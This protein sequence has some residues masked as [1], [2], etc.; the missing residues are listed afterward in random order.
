L[1][2]PTLER[3]LLENLESQGR[4][5]GQGYQAVVRRISSEFGEFVVKSPHPNNPL[6]ALFGRRAISREA[7]VY[8]R[9][10]GIQGIPR[11]FGLAASKHLVLEHVNGMTLRGAASALADRERFFDRLLAT[12]RAMHEAGIAHGDM[13]RK[14]N[15]LVSADET[16]CIIDFGVACLLKKKGGWLNRQRFE[17][18]RQMD[19][20]AWIKLKH[21]RVPESLPAA[22]AA[23]Y[24]PLPI[25]RWARRARGPWK[26]LSLR[27][28]RKRR[29]EAR[30]QA[31]GPR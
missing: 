4:I 14:E 23:L 12:I 11:S 3:W 6:L 10:D 15:T 7:L 20:N 9:L 13:K 29:R 26:A 8:E 2:D 25:E 31:P 28:L 24:R 21:G 22:E 1:I 17:I 30:D 16:P 27:K 5:I 18:T 19:L